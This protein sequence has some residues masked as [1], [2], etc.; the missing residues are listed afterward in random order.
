MLRA[1]QLMAGLVHWVV[2]YVAVN[3][4]FCTSAVRWYPLCGAGDVVAAALGLAVLVLPVYFCEG[5][6][7]DP[8]RGVRLSPLFHGSSWWAVR[9][10]SVSVVLCICCQS[11]A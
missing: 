7:M 8:L 4:C 3:F 5:A 9:P 10:P 11:T 6:W 2:V 1:L